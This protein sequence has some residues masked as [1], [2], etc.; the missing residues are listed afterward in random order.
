MAVMEVSG[1]DESKKL[2]EEAWELVL[3]VE[4]EQALVVGKVE[5]KCWEWG[6]GWVV[7]NWGV[8]GDEEN[9]AK[10]EKHSNQKAIRWHFC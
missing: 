10:L 1:D 7:W 6:W 3:A 4:L 2:V 9:R 5:V 8:L